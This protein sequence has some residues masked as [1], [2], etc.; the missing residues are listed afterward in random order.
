MLVD[1]KFATPDSLTSW[2]REVGAQNG[3][4]PVNEVSWEDGSVRMRGDASTRSWT[5]LTRNVDVAGA[6]WL[7]MR[8]R[9]RTDG[10][11]PAQAGF[12]NC[13]LFLRHGKGVVGTRVVT[14]AAEAVEVRRRIELPAGTQRVA[15]GFFSSMPGTAWFDDVVLE[16]SEAPRFSVER[17][18]RYRYSLL[19]GD[20]IDD[21]AR[22]FNDE[23]FRLVSAYLGVEGPAEVSFMKYPDVATLEELTGFAGNAFRHKQV[24]HSIWARDRHEI[25]HVLADAWGDPPALLGEGIAVY[26]SGSWQHKPVKDYARDVARGGRWIAPSS[27]LASLAFRRHPDL[28]SYPIAGAFVEWIERTYGKD[29]LKSAYA[30]LMNRASVEDNTRALEKRLRSTLSKIDADYRAWVEKE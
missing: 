19:P 7:A 26:L 28:D 5:A 20:A 10:L 24:I 9:I 16:K 14:G 25:V 22:A 13:N 27:M 30:E 21:K 1:E 29:T 3:E 15:F 18:G 12:P 17:H 23:S 6:D 8:G 11:D 4:T 2:G